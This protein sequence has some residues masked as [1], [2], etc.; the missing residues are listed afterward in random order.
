MLAAA[1]K[2]SALPV[3]C[4][5]SLLV[6]PLPPTQTRFHPASKPWLIQF[7]EVPFWKVPFLGKCSGQPMFLSLST[8]KNPGHC[9]TSTRRHTRQR[10]SELFGLSFLLQ[11]PK[12]LAIWKYQQ[13]QT[14]HAPQQKSGPSY[15]RTREGAAQRGKTLDSSHS[16]LPTP[17]STPAQ[18]S[19]Q[20]ARD[21]GCGGESK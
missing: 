8:T 11:K 15:R 21:L 5:N 10:G 1:S 20:S 12:K 3:D 7:W 9:K 18:A 6:S 19:G 14:K 2:S 17:P 13:A 16:V 4:R